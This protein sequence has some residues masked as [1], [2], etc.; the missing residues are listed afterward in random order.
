MNIENLDSLSQFFVLTAGEIKRASKVVLP[1]SQ[2]NLIDR[3]QA[4]N[5]H[6]S[7]V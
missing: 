3:F 1:I 2:R 6:V 5:Q 4:C 7:F